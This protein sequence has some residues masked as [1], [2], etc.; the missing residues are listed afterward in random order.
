MVLTSRQVVGNNSALTLAYDI[1]RPFG[2]ISSVG[3]HQ[4]PPLPFTGR[5]VYNK[6]VSFDF[7]RCPVRAMFPIA[8][9][10]LLKRQDVFGG[11]GEE[12]SLIDRIVSFDEAPQV[13]EDFD[14]GRCGKILFD[15]WR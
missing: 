7:G 2:I 11:I 3:V 13:Y 14:K 15:P 9:E 5:D 8:L 1:V 4:E 6:N 10:I 12:A